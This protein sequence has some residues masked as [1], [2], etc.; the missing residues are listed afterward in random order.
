MQDNAKLPNQ[1]KA[2]LALPTKE[3]LAE[4]QGKHPV[5][6]LRTE[7]N[8]DEDTPVEIIVYV[9]KPLKAHM[10]RFVKTAARDNWKAA[11]SLL[12]DTML[13]PTRENR[14]VLFD[15]WPGLVLTIANEV[16]K[17]GGVADFTMRHLGNG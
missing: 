6:E 10:M 2:A 14:K 3:E 8:L 16:N 4:L 1:I 7:V 17:L 11:E 15:Q 5:Y 13:W 9:R 12:E